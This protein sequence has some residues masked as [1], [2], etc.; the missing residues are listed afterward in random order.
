MARGPQPELGAYFSAAV[1]SGPDHDT[2]TGLCLSLELLSTRLPS[3]LEFVLGALRE[4][5]VAPEVK[6]REAT[7]TLLDRLASR[8]TEQLIRQV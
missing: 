3:S 5:V 8:C 6:V 1:G 2:L 4:L 7:A